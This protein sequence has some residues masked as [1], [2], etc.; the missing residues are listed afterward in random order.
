MLGESVHTLDL[1][2]PL[3]VT[4]FPRSEI[5]AEE[6]SPCVARGR[7]YRW[8]LYL[9]RWSVPHRHYPPEAGPGDGCRKRDS[10][11]LELCQLVS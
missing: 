8:N 1:I 5:M 10:A 4:D 9:S 7:V 6:Q 11:R 3:C 2:E